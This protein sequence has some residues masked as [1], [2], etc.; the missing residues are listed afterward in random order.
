MTGGIQFVT[1]NQSLTQKP[2]AGAKFCR[3]F[4]LQTEQKSQVLVAVPAKEKG[5]REF[6]FS[7][8][9]RSPKKVSW[10]LQA[11]ATKSL[12]LNVLDLSFKF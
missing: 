1:V 12:F 8:W 10:P 5:A 11:L 2:L 7:K 9:E 4:R 6:P 3:Q